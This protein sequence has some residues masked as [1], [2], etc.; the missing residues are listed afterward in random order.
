MFEIGSHP[1]LNLCLPASLCFCLSLNIASAGIMSPVPG[2]TKQK[3]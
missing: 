2:V 1:L 3:A